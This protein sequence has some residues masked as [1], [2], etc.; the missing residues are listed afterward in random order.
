MLCA[1][2]NPLVTEN[3]CL[4]NGISTLRNQTRKMEQSNAR[5]NQR[6]I[7][8]RPAPRRRRVD[9]QQFDKRAAFAVEAA[10]A[11]DSSHFIS[12][13]CEIISE[14]VST[15]LQITGWVGAGEYVGE[16]LGGWEA[17]AMAAINGPLV[18]KEPPVERTF[19]PWIS[20]G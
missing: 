1:H 20:V 9:K 16:R 12:T 6:N 3:S 5:R 10:V 2:P 7:D 18:V 11:Y 8:T 17:H 15:G 19:G 14:L 4:G 13:L